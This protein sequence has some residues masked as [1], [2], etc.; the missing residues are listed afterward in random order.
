MNRLIVASLLLVCLTSLTGCAVVTVTSAVIG[1]AVTAVEVTT[2][3]AVATGK[4]VVKVGG[5]AVDAAS[6][7]APEAAEAAKTAK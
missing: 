3:V 2:D 4:G 5:W 1:T 7:D 6:K